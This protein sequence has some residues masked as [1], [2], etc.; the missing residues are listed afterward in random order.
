MQPKW[1]ENTEN[2]PL[3]EERVLVLSSGSISVEV[4]RGALLTL[5][6]TF[7]T[8]RAADKH[9]WGV[10]R[11]KMCLAGLVSFVNTLIQSWPWSEYQL[12][13]AQRSLIAINYSFLFPSA[14]STQSLSADFL[15]D[16]IQTYVEETEWCRQEAVDGLSS[17]NGAYM[18]KICSV[19]L[20]N[21]KQD[22]LVPGSRWK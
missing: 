1:N 19:C 10:S 2:T 15:L 11:Y 8:E 17:S 18:N 7:S 6:R 14:A 22:L 9:N 3:Q 16:F 21:G 12:L 13:W 5:Q 4:E 20:K